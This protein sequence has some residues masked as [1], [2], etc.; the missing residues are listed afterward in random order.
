LGVQAGFNLTE[1]RVAEQVL[2]AL[3]SDTPVYL[4][5]RFYDF[6]PLRFLVY[7]AV[8]SKTGH[9]TLDDRPY[10][11]ARPEQDLP[12]PDTGHDALFLLDT[13]YEPVMD[14]FRLWYP[15]ADIEKVYWRDE[16]PVYIRARVPQSEL[17][18][19]QSLNAR[20]TRADGGVEELV[21][22]GVDEIWP[23]REV[24][25]AEWNG[26]LRLEHSGDYDFVEQGG[27]TVTVDGQLWTGHRFLCSGLHD[28]Q[29]VQP[30]SSRQNVARLSWRTPM[31]WKR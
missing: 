30:D 20:L 28:L 9:N 10:R 6:S 27:L 14:Y 29:V 15:G 2:L 26:S 18:A 1:N 24:A 3:E 22:S 11:L 12:V 4:S 17:A 16:V 31:A 25:S 23:Q 21:V 19:I 13:Y 7:G 8:K 5:P